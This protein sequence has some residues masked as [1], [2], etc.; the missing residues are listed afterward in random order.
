MRRSKDDALCALCLHEAT[1]MDPIITRPIYL[2][3][4]LH[5]WQSRHYL[6]VS[7]NTSSTFG[8]QFSIRMIDQISSNVTDNQVYKRVA[9]IT[10]KWPPVMFTLLTY[11]NNINV[12]Q[13]PRFL[14]WCFFWDVTPCRLV[15]SNQPFEGSKI[16]A[17]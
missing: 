9:Y 12:L 6:M 5:L 13:D 2:Y 10:K 17:P 3:K 11:C 4:Q 1:L 15:S 7:H 8:V 16:K 14:H